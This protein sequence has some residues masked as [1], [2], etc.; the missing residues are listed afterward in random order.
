M[1]PPEE[2]SYDLAQTKIVDEMVNVE[3]PKHEKVE[4]SVTTIEN[5]S[6][7]ETAKLCDTVEKEI[8]SK[9]IPIDTF[10]HSE[11][12]DLHET[13]KTLINPTKAKYLITKRIEPEKFAETA[14]YD[15]QIEEDKRTTPISKTEEKLL[16]SKQNV[17][18]LSPEA[19][20]S[21]R[22]KKFNEAVNNEV[23][24]HKKLEL[25]VETKENESIEAEDAK[26]Y[27]RIEKEISG[28]EIQ[29]DAI[30]HSEKNF[31]D[32]PFKIVMTSTEPEL[33]MTEGMKSELL[34]EAKEEDLQMEEDKS[35]TLYETDK[36]SPTEKIIGKLTPETKKNESSELKIAEFYEPIEKELPTSEESTSEHFNSQLPDETAQFDVT[37]ETS[38]TESYSEVLTTNSMTDPLDTKSSLKS[39]SCTETLRTSAE[40]FDYDSSLE[41]LKDDLSVEQLKSC[42]SSIKMDDESPEKMKT[43]TASMISKTSESSEIK[44]SSMSAEMSQ[45]VEGRRKD[46]SMFETRDS[47]VKVQTNESAESA[48][49]FSL[50]LNLAVKLSNEL[51]ED[52]DVTPVEIEPITESKTV[53][54]LTEDEKS[55]SSKEKNRSKLLID[56]ATEDKL[57]EATTS[58]KVTS[59]VQH[60]SLSE[61]KPLLLSEEKSCESMNKLM[62]A[63]TV[64][65]K[66][67]IEADIAEIA[68]TSDGK[69]L[70]ELSN[71]P[72][73]GIITATLNEVNA[74]SNDDI[75]FSTSSTITST[76]GP[77]EQSV[78]VI[79]NTNSES[80]TL[81][82]D[83][84]S[85]AVDN[86]H[87]V[88]S[89]DAIVA[90]SNNSLN[91]PHH[92]TFVSSVV[93][94]NEIDPGS[95]TMESPISSQS[96]DKSSDDLSSEKSSNSH[97][98]KMRN[99]PKQVLSI[100]VCNKKGIDM[101]LETDSASKEI[102][103]HQDIGSKPEFSQKNNAKEEIE[104]IFEESPL[105]S[106][107]LVK[108]QIKNSLSG[109]QSTVKEDMMVDANNC[110]HS[111]G[112]IQRIPSEP[113]K[114]LKLF[115]ESGS[116]C[117]QQQLNTDKVS[118]ETTPNIDIN[119]LSNKDMHR[120]TYPESVE[121]FD[122]NSHLFT[123]EG[124]S[125]VEFWDG[126]EVCTSTTVLET[127]EQDESG[128]LSE[129]SGKEIMQA[130]SLCQFLSCQEEALLE[131]Q[132]C[133]SASEVPEF[134]LHEKT[135]A[136][137]PQFIDMKLL[138]FMDKVKAA[139]LLQNSQE[140]QDLRIQEISM[141]SLF[142]MSNFH[143]LESQKNIFMQKIADRVNEL[144]TPCSDTESSEQLSR[145]TCF[146]QVMEIIYEWLE[147]LKAWI[148]KV[149]VLPADEHALQFKLIDGELEAVKEQLT[150]VEEITNSISLSLPNEHQQNMA[151]CLADI[152]NLVDSTEESAKDSLQLIT[153]WSKDS[154][155]IE[156]EYDGLLAQL[157]SF[158]TEL[159]AEK[160]KKYS[161][162]KDI[163]ALKLDAMEKLMSC[164]RI[165]LLC[166][167]KIKLSLQWPGYQLRDIEPTLDLASSVKSMIYELQD[168]NLDNIS[169]HFVSTNI[170][171]CLVEIAEK[172]FLD[173]ISI[174]DVND[175]EK[176]CSHSEKC[177]QYL[178][179]LMSSAKS[180][181]HTVSSLLDEGQK[182][183]FESLIHR[184]ENVLVRGE[185][186]M[187]SWSIAKVK[188]DELLRLLKQIS[189][190]LEKSQID[191][192]QSC[193]KDVSEQKLQFIVLQQEVLDH[194]PLIEHIMSLQAKVK[195]FV[196][197]AILNSTVNDVLEKYSSLNRN[198]DFTLINLSQYLEQCTKFEEDLSELKKWLSDV[199]HRC[200]YIQSEHVGSSS[201][202][203][204]E[205]IRNVVRLKSD[206]KYRENTYSRIES[207]IE[208][209]MHLELDNLPGKDTISSLSEAWDDSWKLLSLLESEDLNKFSNI[210]PEIAESL[211]NWALDVEKTYCDKNIK[212]VSSLAEL[213]VLLN[214]YYG[215][216]EEL[217][218]I[219]D[220]TSNAVKPTDRIKESEFLYHE[221]PTST[222][223]ILSVNKLDDLK[224]NV[225]YDIGKI[226]KLVIYWSEI[227]RLSSALEA[228]LNSICFDLKSIMGGNAKKNHFS[229]MRNRKKIQKHQLE[230]S[231]KEK[232]FILFKH[233]CSI[234]DGQFPNTFLQ[235]HSH[236]KR[237]E[238]EQLFSF[239]EENLSSIK[240]SSHSDMM[241]WSDYRQVLEKSNRVLT[242]SELML[243]LYS[244][245]VL[246]MEHLDF[247]ISKLQIAVEE[248]AGNVSVLNEASMCAQNLKETC[249][250]GAIIEVDSDLEVLI[251]RWDS[252]SNS[253][254]KSLQD[255]ECLRISN[256]K[257][258][259][260][261]DSLLKWIKENEAVIRSL[262][263]MRPCNYGKY[264]T[265]LQ[266]VEEKK[267]L[268][269]S[270]QQ[271]NNEINQNSIIHP[272]LK[273][274]L[275]ASLKFVDASIN[276]FEANLNLGHKVLFSVR[277]TKS[278]GEKVFQ[279]VESFLDNMDEEQC[280]KI[281][282]I[283]EETS[284][285]IQET[286]ASLKALSVHYAN[287]QCV[288]GD[289]ILKEVSDFS[290]VQKSNSLLL[291][292]QESIAKMSSFYFKLMEAFSI[293]SPLSE[294]I[295]FI[296][297]F[298]EKFKGMHCDETPSQYMA[299]LDYLM[300]TQIIDV[301]IR[302]CEIVIQQT[303]GEILKKMD[304]GSP[305]TAEFSR[306][307]TKFVVEWNAANDIHA[308]KM[309]EM[310][311]IFT[312]WQHYLLLRVKLNSLLERI[313]Q[314]MKM[315][316][317]FTNKEEMR[318]RINSIQNLLKAKE[319][320]L[321]MLTELE[322][323]CKQ[324]QTDGDMAF[325]KEMLQDVS[326]FKSKISEQQE[327]LQ[328]ENSHLV[329]ISSL[330]DE[331]NHEIEMVDR[332]LMS[333]KCFINE[334]SSLNAKGMIKH[335]QAA[336]EQRTVV[337]K[338][339][340]TLDSLHSL[341]AERNEDISN[342][343]YQER[344]LFQKLFASVLND[345]LNFKID[346]TTGEN[347]RWKAFNKTGLL[348][349]EW[350][351]GIEEAMKR[352]Q[353][354]DLESLIEEMRMTIH[355]E[356]EHKVKAFEE[357]I[358]FGEMLVKSGEIQE[359]GRELMESLKDVPS[360]IHT[361][362]HER[363]ESCNA[364]LE[365]Q[366][367]VDDL[368]LIL[369]QTLTASEVDLQ[370]VIKSRAKSETEIKNKLDT[371]EAI[372][373]NLE[374]HSHQMNTL[375]ENLNKLVIKS[376]EI[377]CSSNERVQ[378][379][380]E[381]ISKRWN[382]LKVHLLR[383]QTK[384][385]NLNMAWSK[386]FSG[387]NSLEA[388]LSVRE[389]MASEIDY[390]VP[391]HSRSSYLDGMRTFEN[392]NHSVQD[393]IQL[394]HSVNREYH[395]VVS[396][397]KE[398]DEDLRQRVSTANERWHKLYKIIIEQEERIKE[399]LEIWEEFDRK[400][401]HLL[402]FLTET[403][404]KLTALEQSK[405]WT[406]Q[407]L[408]DIQK[409]FEIHEDDLQDLASISVSVQKS[410]RCS[411][412]SI[413]ADVNEIEV[414]WTQL[415]ERLFR[416]KEI[417]VLN[418]KSISMDISSEKL[419]SPESSLDIAG[420]A[421]IETQNE[422][423]DIQVDIN[424]S[425]CPPMQDD[426]AVKVDT[427]EM[428]FSVDL[429]KEND[430]Q[431]IQADI[432]TTDSLAGE[433]D[434]ES[435]D[436]VR[437]LLAA[438]REAEERMDN[439]EMV[440]S[441]LTPDGSE[442]DGGPNYSRLVAACRSSIDV[443]QHLNHFLLD[444]QLGQER[445]E[446]IQHR[447][448]GM[449]SRWE[450]IESTALDKEHRSLSN[451]RRWQH[452][453]ENLKNIESWL[454]EAVKTYKE[455]SAS[456][457]HFRNIVSLVEK[458]KELVTSIW[459]QKENILTL[460]STALLFMSTA[461][462]VENRD[463]LNLKLK[464][465]NEHWDNLCS[466]AF[467]WQQKL[468][469]ELLESTDFKNTISEMEQWLNES[470][471][472]I[473]EISSMEMESNSQIHEQQT[474]LYA[475]KQQLESCSN[476]LE[477]FTEIIRYFLN[478]NLHAGKSST[479]PEKERVLQLQSR[480]EPL[481]KLCLSLLDT[482]N[483][484]L[485]YFAKLSRSEMGAEVEKLVSD[486]VSSLQ[487]PDD[488]PNR[489]REYCSFL[490][491]VAR[492]S[493]PIQA[494]LLLLLGA[495][496][497][498]PL[499]EEEEL[500]CRL[501][502]NF[503]KSLNPML[504]YPDGPPPV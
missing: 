233:L 460:N 167:E 23:V 412:E 339:V 204:V 281:P 209:V 353:T 267:L 189:D 363:L 303:I 75:T 251:A 226:E 118:L 185:K 106:D 392:L 402:L 122:D 373:A 368:I 92:D 325:L 367:S 472:R 216:A 269:T 496:I 140:N 425:S 341:A 482:C 173:S 340:K 21:T 171:K 336:E 125:N 492:A 152:A 464:A 199:K 422:S 440:L 183:D 328:S 227:N 108:D 218:V 105:H 154:S 239:I 73:T 156:K 326:H 134:G 437:D 24:E 42:S 503:A 456:D 113:I 337:E 271:C 188:M 398:V 49:D 263:L 79:S 129:S 494:V 56:G 347:S 52:S 234:V 378:Q 286:E 351:R 324:L 504:H 35:I 395:D 83:E 459:N 202:D 74:I 352:K 446:D 261:Y 230:L 304:S 198:V 421:I 172:L 228:S 9:E 219:E 327:S 225:E 5:E 346:H 490:M 32:Q 87:S 293:N 355:P 297:Q 141:P 502:N 17:V 461:K 258:V 439:L 103:A 117:I 114:D 130:T 389:C 246:N 411:V 40:S 362:F 94:S 312:T 207:A 342:F 120:D 77:V 268:L 359:N 270:M 310:K 356:V 146:F 369:D 194:L 364:L 107:I 463:L 166:L 465:V 332:N 376:E 289:M 253:L 28:E 97:L 291:R 38:E 110:Q 407:E 72:V 137:T 331:L 495:A 409:E 168:G 19:D 467:S 112:F 16:T 139:H 358:S 93:D 18:E 196:D 201:A 302:G 287:L 382:I 169:L 231:Q 333:V 307:L 319:H 163:Q 445:V 68:E 7:L 47:M 306:Y 410:S 305:S 48:K 223:E 101:S 208:Q 385:K 420:T 430:T 64:E 493:F 257:W 91:L 164:S 255:L 71:V 102:V 132:K 25:S 82:P 98:T 2:L 283:K 448:K 12:S 444:N 249:D 397:C 418:E 220:V 401:E 54:A 375:N 161:T 486:A 473:Q 27:D 470:E 95:E 116:V 31:S 335:E 476:S 277:S 454:D 180:N 350:S 384:L 434:S 3:S 300:Q 184:A 206:F 475:L 383:R 417:K 127:P 457:I 13:G 254:R 484:R 381:N 138:L 30:N 232:E 89:Y 309:F 195:P 275:E 366:K 211:N 279:A 59:A 282:S 260:E 298:L 452:F 8:L 491:R 488:Q 370:N 248:L 124:T 61:E 447:T 142:D 372:Q 67:R 387:L 374:S 148:I 262:S 46:D 212:D 128:V 419:E 135:A 323:L 244:G 288:R 85:N 70:G 193:R 480:L 469:C 276:S 344:I 349:L 182:G 192:G 100:D 158:K 176:I 379:I 483:E 119:D 177:L 200:K 274:Q 240:S 408:A 162:T 111:V 247:N 451:I 26:F 396:K 157:S 322:N 471:E 41:S 405:S 365:D 500:S 175:M 178:V 295:Q 314:E 1:E 477:N 462:K 99:K 428:Q 6:E 273:M 235:D 121:N 151:A 400:K 88:P 39:S 501:S 399:V 290:I 123:N 14:E 51:L 53:E 390:S 285:L 433:V 66:P 81:V 186:S 354:K 431:S 115:Q 272:V 155:N 292:I 145:V 423:S 210:T 468:Q 90:N 499:E 413:K 321:A 215:L 84:G 241:Q 159:E 487:H 229:T 187:N 442:D 497:F 50:P 435:E 360:K 393:N 44:A 415:Y 57:T 361:L 296:I 315:S 391:E 160:Q 345:Q 22:E 62:K 104:N 243:M 181:Y 380:C 250:G 450:K 63:E 453:T 37:P 386:V 414:Y 205:N 338:A 264:D 197:C 259:L 432:D 429:I 343:K 43:E 299:L 65:T 443:I 426:E 222:N 284:A 150:K 474:E 256:E 238:I 388:W 224:F 11:E 466:T 60:E 449:I 252:M 86:L 179:V 214:E 301:Y 34:P 280:T 109:E 203:L 278:E 33:L 479:P 406:E 481:L 320:P 245:P 76:S 153:Q 165:E 20:S 403:D 313:D 149:S 371:I 45:D 144:C 318:R 58:I 78:F 136:D 311:K 221:L 242:Q 15:S 217:R 424:V 170:L 265:I 404:L 334:E 316:L 147:F 377:N 478:E 441:E 36:H 190:W 126:K 143:H 29:N 485:L 438:L 55:G 237:Q 174:A 394:L 80:P 329:E 436:F 133:F 498:M 191:E 69:L 416:L 427:E 308:K 489:A 294:K 4:L 455:E 10:I 348:L 96:E 330:C 213:K 317:K 266:N 236:S 357:A 458:Q 131:L